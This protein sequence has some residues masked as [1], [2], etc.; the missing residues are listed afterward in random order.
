MGADVAL[1]YGLF[2]HEAETEQL[3]NAGYDCLGMVGLCSMRC[4]I[5]LWFPRYLI[6]VLKAISWGFGAL[7]MIF[8]F[9]SVSWLESNNFNLRCILTI[10]LILVLSIRKRVELNRLMKMRVFCR[11]SWADFSLE[12]IL[13]SFYLLIRHAKLVCCLFFL[14]GKRILDIVNIIDKMNVLHD[15]FVVKSNDLRTIYWGRRELRWNVL[16]R[17]VHGWMQ[18]WL[19]CSI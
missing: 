15:F 8:L 3:R 16:V 2:T 13:P 12:I 10:L 14:F 7:W 9:R 18:V 5:D 11:R 19:L 1:K 4:D 17:F 6:W